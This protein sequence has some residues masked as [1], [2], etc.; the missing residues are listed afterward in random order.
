[1]YLAGSAGYGAIK[2]LELV[3]SGQRNSYV[4]IMGWEGAQYSET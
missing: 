1:M 2:F 4:G 3:P